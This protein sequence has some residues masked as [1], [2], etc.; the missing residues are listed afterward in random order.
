MGGHFVQ[1]HVDTVAEI[2]STKEDG[3][4]LVL[5]LRPR[6]RSVLRYV[7]EKG[8]VALDGASL[9]VTAVA[10]GD[11]DGDSGGGGDG[12]GWFE[13]ML[14]AYTQE[15]I[16]TAKKGKGDEV[17]VEVDMVGKYVEKNVA[18]YF[19]AEGEKGRN[20]WIQKIIEQTVSK[21]AGGASG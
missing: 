9:T 14:V 4:A 2:L 6:D 13:I 21:T 10:G 7:V 3:N 12:K 11:G 5:R 16:V 1:G 19:A 17:N 18:A 15:K 20:G 8:Y